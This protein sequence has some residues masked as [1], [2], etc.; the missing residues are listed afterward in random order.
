MDIFKEN[1]TAIQVI[2]Y[3]E[4][5]ESAIRQFICTCYS[6][7]DKNWLLNPKYQLGTIILQE[8]KEMMNYEKYIYFIIPCNYI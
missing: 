7:Y 1:E 8:Q 3:P 5:V 2:V 4:D 6:E